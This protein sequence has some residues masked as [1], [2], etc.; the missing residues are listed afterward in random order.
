MRRRVE[1]FQQRSFAGGVVAR[2][3]VEPGMKFYINIT[4]QSEILRA[5]AQDPHEMSAQSRIGMTT[6]R[7]CGCCGSN[8]KPLASGP[9]SSMVKRSLLIASS[10]SSK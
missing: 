5:Y 4:Q 7:F 10:A 9:R 2:D 8:S 6:N 1:R 3:Q